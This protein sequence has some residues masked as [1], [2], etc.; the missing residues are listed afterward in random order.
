[1]YKIDVLIQGFPGKSV[2][3]GGLG[4]ST[5]AVLRGEGR[6]I[7]MDTGSFG[8]RRHLGE[9]LKKH[10]VVPGDVTD[11]VL[12]HAHYDHSVNF[13]LFPN[14]RVYIGAIELDWAQKQPPGFN[15]LPELYV[16]ELV[17]Y[18]KL[19]LLEDGQQDF[20]P[21]MSAHI[22]PGHTPGSL[23]Y[24]LK[25]GPTNVV[26]TGDAAKNRAELLSMSA[27]MTYDAAISLKSFETIW[28]LW[29]EVPGSLLIP[30]HDLSMLIGKDGRPEYV[31]K[32]GAA[33]LGWFGESIE[34]TTEINLCCDPPQRVFSSLTA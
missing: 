30:G 15:P 25:N 17:N 26:F 5:V 33:I 28:G 34:E 20:L 13:T 18:P 12:S 1:M 4:W 31:G 16:R 2:C 32:R 3:H 14:A 9:Q 6:T 29:R 8:M 7:L 22:T 21:G 24:S 10:G 23:V 11:V 27:D 19:T